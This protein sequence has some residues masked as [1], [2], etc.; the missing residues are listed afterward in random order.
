MI[1]WW[2][3]PSV[4]RGWVAVQPTLDFS[5]TDLLEGMNQ[6]NMHG[7]KF[8]TKVSCAFYEKSISLRVDRP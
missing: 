8:L 5:N 7:T 3:L 1:C 4:C 6:V 2:L